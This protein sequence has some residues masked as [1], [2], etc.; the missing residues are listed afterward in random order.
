VDER[1][2]QFAQHIGVV[3][4]SHSAGSAGQSILWAAVIASI[5]VLE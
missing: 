2:E 4:V 1:S 5:S 3:V